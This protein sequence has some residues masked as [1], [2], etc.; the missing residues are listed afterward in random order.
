MNKVLSHLMTR[1]EITTWEYSK[2]N[3]N[4]VHNIHVLFC[5]DLHQTI[6]GQKRLKPGKAGMAYARPGISR[7]FSEFRTLHD[8]LTRD[9]FQ[10]PPLPPANPWVDFWI[11][12]FPVPTLATRLRSLQDVLDVINLSP[13]MQ[14]TPAFKTFLGPTPD[15]RLGY[16]TLR[17]YSTVQ[18]G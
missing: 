2:N 17:E 16:T 4:A 14:A 15:T 5:I 18:C 7:R 6:S 10:L 1:L 13:P 3:V 11:R 12:Y 8:A 9:G